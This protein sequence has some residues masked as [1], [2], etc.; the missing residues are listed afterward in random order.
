MLYISEIIINLYVC[1]FILC[2]IFMY[3]NMYCVCVEGGEEPVAGH[4]SANDWTKL[5]S[6][7]TSVYGGPYNPGKVKYIS[8]VQRSGN[9][10]D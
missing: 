1:I 6:K 7:L 2:V 3:I 8:D 5:T 4:L 9:H 10:L